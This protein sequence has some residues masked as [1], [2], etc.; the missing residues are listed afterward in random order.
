MSHVP[1]QLNIADKA[2]AD[3]EE[4]S[5]YFAQRAPDVTDRFYQAVKRTI[6]QL[7]R[8]PA[9]GERC[10]FRNPATKGM[11]IWQVDGFS[12]YLIFYRLNGEQLEILRILHGARNYET[13]FNEE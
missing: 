9:L 2:S 12:N 6:Q 13:M 1:L 7:L 10:R 11:R 4:I 8:S 3:I 5:F